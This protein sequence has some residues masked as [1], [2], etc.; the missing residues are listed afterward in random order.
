M[1]TATS[2]DPAALLRAAQVVID[3][4]HSA[5]RGVWPKAAALLGRQALE[6]AISQRFP[7]IANASGRARNLCLPTLLGDRELARDLIQ[8]W[9]ALSHATHY[10]A[11][12]LSPTATELE[13]WLEPVARLI[14]QT[15][16]PR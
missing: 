11:H 12:D 3:R 6:T 9:G 2:S 7:E 1:S 10:H 5:T 13:H 16:D 4:R 15:S 8:S 14:D